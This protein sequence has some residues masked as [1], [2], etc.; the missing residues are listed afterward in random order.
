MH[1]SQVLQIPFA[2][3][4]LSAYVKNLDGV[5]RTTE[6]Q[7]IHLFDN[8]SSTAWIGSLEAFH[9]KYGMYE[10]NKNTT[11]PWIK[12]T[13]I[14]LFIHVKNIV[15]KLAKIDQSTYINHNLCSTL[16]WDASPSTFAKDIINTQSDKAL[17]FRSL[18]INNVIELKKHFHNNFVIVPF[19]KA[20]YFNPSQPLQGKIKKNFQKDNAL[21]I[22]NRYDIVTESDLRPDDYERIS[23]LYNMLYIDKFVNLNPTYTIDF[24]KEITNNKRFSY[25]CLRKNGKIDAF[26]LIEENGDS[27]QVPC[28]GYDTILPRETGLY[29]QLTSSLLG[30][31]IM[32]KLNFYMSSGCSDY[33]ENRGASAYTEYYGVY[34][35]N[36]N[37]VRKLSWKL[38]SFLIDKIW[39][40]IVNKYF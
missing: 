35:G 20:F 12:K 40:K 10:I 25:L 14:L 9:I 1:Q 18:T 39:L 11:L 26:A 27:M 34:L 2:N 22:K 30:Y 37:F 6:N 13:L 36:V 7:N 8:G 23:E 5:F 28:V 29:R 15:A 32:N 16:L 17:I 4:N 24:F 19:R 31:S 3:K 33:K 21:F 38:F